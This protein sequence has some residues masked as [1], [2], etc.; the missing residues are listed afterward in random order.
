VP[1]L[2][3]DVAVLLEAG[4]ASELRPEAA[5]RCGVLIRRRRSSAGLYAIDLTPRTSYAR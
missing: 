4:A 1:G 3:E 2:A 5:L